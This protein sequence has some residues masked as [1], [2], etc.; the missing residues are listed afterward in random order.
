M[1]AG[2]INVLLSI[3]LIYYRLVILLQSTIHKQRKARAWVEI[4]Q[5]V[6]FQS[7]VSITLSDSSNSIKLMYLP[8]YCRVVVH[9]SMGLQSFTA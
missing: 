4:C 9:T 8:T 3:V 6:D 5:L 1:C 7:T 2:S